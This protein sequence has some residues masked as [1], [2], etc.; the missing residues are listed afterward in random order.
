MLRKRVTGA[1]E[2]PLDLRKEKAPGGR[3]RGKRE[4]QR[5]GECAQ[6]GVPWGKKRIGKGRHGNAQEKERIQ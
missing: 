6:V 4:R 5:E 3:R 1:K 2:R